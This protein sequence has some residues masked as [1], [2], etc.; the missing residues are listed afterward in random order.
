MEISA[1]RAALKSKVQDAEARGLRLA[2]GG[3]PGK[4]P[5][6]CPGLVFRDLRARRYE[7]DG[8]GT[9]CILGAVVLDSEGSR[10]G[11]VFDAGQVLGIP[12]EEAE[13]IECGFE[14]WDWRRGERADALVRLG[15][16]FSPA[17]QPLP[18]CLPLLDH[19]VTAEVT[20]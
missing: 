10:G 12:E 15:S 9:C 1:I 18:E 5:A 4:V 7:P 14:G 20:R 2:R 6:G 11:Y 19:N 16:E 8:S 3:I 17:C 13:L